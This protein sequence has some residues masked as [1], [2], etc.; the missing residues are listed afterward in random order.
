MKKFG[1]VLMA[2][3]I[4]VGTPA[5][6]LAKSLPEPVVMEMVMMLPI[7]HHLAIYEQWVF[8]HPPHGVILGILPDATHL[9]A[10]GGHIDSKDAHDVIITAPVNSCAVR[11]QV[12][13]NEHSGAYT[14]P[15][16]EST[17]VVVLL[18]P[19]SLAMP[20]VLNPSLAFNGQGR[21]PLPKMAASPVFNEYVTSHLM[22]GSALP[23]IVEQANNLVSPSSTRFAGH[24]YPGIGQGFQIAM[25]LLSATA[26]LMAFSWRK[27]FG[28]S[29]NSWSH[30]M[31]AKNAS[32]HQGLV[33]DFTLQQDITHIPTHKGSHQEG[34]EKV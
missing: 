26:I 7:Q 14:L 16:Y 18:V 9:R 22:A 25:V 27:L 34:P 21:I 33:D 24:L 12:P 1:W 13:W 30:D 28:L 29:S 31:L 23:L 11:Y 32:F 6:V 3:M 20:A 10:I 4:A 2:G 19:P 8:S 15:S 17:G 5:G